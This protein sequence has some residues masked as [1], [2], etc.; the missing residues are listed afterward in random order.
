L[1]V[2]HIVG[3]LNTLADILSRTVERNRYVLDPTVLFQC[4]RKFDFD[5]FGSPIH[6]L[7]PNFPTA[8]TYRQ[9]CLKELPPAPTLSV[10]APPWP[11][12][13]PLLSEAAADRK[14]I[15]ASAFIILPYWPA[16]PWWPLAV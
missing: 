8:S 9:R 11:R 16:Q 12:I 7:A 3:E 2:N 1:H 5:L 4:K 10:V 13:L 15:K 14:L 6:S